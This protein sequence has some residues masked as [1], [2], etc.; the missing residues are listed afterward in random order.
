MAAP[1]SRT[2]PA[3]GSA[4][5]EDVQHFRARSSA[6]LSGSGTVLADDPALTVR[7]GP[8]SR[9]PLR[10]V[11]DSALRVPASARVYAGAG[12]ALVFT[13]SLDSPRCSELERR[14]VRV[15]LAARSP[16][17]GLQLQPIL[18]RLAQLQAN[19]VWVEAGARLAGALLQEHLV[20]ELIVYIAP[21]LL[22]PQAQPL[23]VLPAIAELTQRWRGRYT[24]C[25]RGRRNTFSLNK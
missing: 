10:V 20:D 5:R 25:T 24:D 11:L 9:Q 6:I 21:S 4:A 3:A 17:G 15:E 19:E 12:E 18:R 13:A 14:G 23:V 2:A 22:G 8:S 16:A 1:R 7:L